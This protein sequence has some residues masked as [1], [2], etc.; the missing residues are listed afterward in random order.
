VGRQSAHRKRGRLAGGSRDFSIF[1]PSGGVVFDAG[2]T[3]ELAAVAAG[4]YPDGRSDNK[5]TEPE[6]VEIGMYG[7]HTF[8]F[9]GAE[10]AAFVAVYQLS[11][12]RNPRL[13]QL[14]ETGS[15]PEGLLAIPS[16]DLFV[17]ANEDDGTIS[18][19]GGSV[20][21]PEAVH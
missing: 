11:T 17:T 14:L 21:A 1:D 4:L 2:A 19:F 15:R 7:S 3:F 16:R 8:A 18:I 12:D 20:L 9:V 13:V 6:G 5:G 10:R